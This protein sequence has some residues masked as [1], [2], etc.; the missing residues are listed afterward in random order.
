[1]KQKNNFATWWCYISGRKVV[2]TGMFIF[3][4]LITKMA[5]PGGE[6]KF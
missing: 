4:N 5:P 6:I 3:Y 2:E 1:M